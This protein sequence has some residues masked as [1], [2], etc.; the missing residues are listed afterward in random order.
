MITRLLIWVTSK[1]NL[2]CPNCSQA[3]TMK[4]NKQ[5]EMPI[6]E[7]DVIV[8]SCL[9]RK[10][11]FDIIELTGGEASLWTFLEYG[12][13]EFSKVSDMVTM[14]TNGN[15]PERVK[16]LGMKTWIVSA[17]QAT[18]EQ[19]KQYEGLS[20]VHYNSHQ[21]KKLPDKPFDNVLPASCCVSRTPD[22][23]HPQN[24]LEYIRGK[25][26]YCCD[27]FAHSEKTGLTDDI[28]CSFEEDFIK[29]FSDKKYDK[30][31]CRW[32]LCNG[33]IWSQL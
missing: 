23:L 17:S 12:F 6:Y 11:H 1:C 25:V 29:K 4:I 15:N 14:V 8:K 18:K 20:N 5:Y 24:A 21:H 7:V 10:I 31:I 16:S 22:G 2:R 27:A 32:C 19:L 28:V 30:E 3:Y 13:A 26:Y 33:K 9:E